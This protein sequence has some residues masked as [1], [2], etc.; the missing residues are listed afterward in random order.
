MSDD[1]DGDDV[2]GNR[3]FHLAMCFI[4]LHNFAFLKIL[5][6]NDCDTNS[7]WLL[8]HFQHEIVSASSICSNLFWF[9]ATSERKLV[10]LSIRSQE[11]FSILFHDILIWL[12][13]FYG[14]GKIEFQRKT[15]FETITFRLVK[16]AVSA[17]FCAQNSKKSF[18]LLAQT[19]SC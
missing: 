14:S 17:N 2:T 19:W 15:L 7:F 4:R 11:K 6:W 9:H 18:W 5:N 12:Q 3:C 8:Y 10:E 16:R 13:A 1:D